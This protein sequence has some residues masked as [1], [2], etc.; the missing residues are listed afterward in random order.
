MPYSVFLSLAHPD[1]EAFGLGGLII[2][3]VQEG[4]RFDYLVAT[5]GARG[6]VQPEFIEQHGSVK[7]T[8]YAELDCAAQKLGF[9]EVMKLDYGDSGMMANDDKNDP[10]CLWQAD[11]TEV[12]GK[13]VA[14]IRRLKPDVVITFDPFGGYGHPDHIFMHKATTRAFY[15]ANNPN[16]FP[17]AGEPFQPKKLY[18]MA[19]PSIYV[20]IGILIARLKRTDPSK[21]GVNQDFNL[22]EVRDNLPELI[23]T[24]VNIRPHLD[25]WDEAAACHAS[26][27]S[28]VR[29]FPTWL[30]KLAVGKQQLTRI[31][32]EWTGG[33]L[34]RCIFEG[35]HD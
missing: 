24:K 22:L 16:E 29:A 9:S 25:A 33:K 26:Q 28:S 3:T 14:E 17:D 7:A 23:T 27:I 1:D 35:L 34:E 19:F 4:H 6:T 11:E 32:P 21:M 30:R 20:K 12:T 10:D 5:D 31:Y 18:Y 8:R 15:A 13:V 2:K